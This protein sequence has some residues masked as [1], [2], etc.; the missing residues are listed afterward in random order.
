MPPLPTF[1]LFSPAF[2]GPL[3]GVPPL[4]ADDDEFPEHPA[5]KLTTRATLAANTI[6]RFIRSPRLI[7][8]Q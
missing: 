5:A 4:L 3:D 7:A 8:D 2:G 1:D 6:V